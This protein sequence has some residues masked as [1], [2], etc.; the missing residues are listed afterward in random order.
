MTHSTHPLQDSAAFTKLFEQHHLAVFRFIYALSGGSLHE[1]EDLTAETFL[2]AWKSRQ[3][4]EGDLNSALGWL[5]TI[6]RHLV[7]DAARRNKVRKVDQSIADLDEWQVLYPQGHVV[8]VENQAIHRERVAVLLGE[9]RNLP[10]DRRELL[11]LRYI[12]GWQVKQIAAHLGMVENTASVYL[13]RA[14]EQIRR[15]WPTEDL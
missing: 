10:A 12:L 2:R 14:L 8:S 5:L 4:F 9:L 15:D 13:H 11:I 7:I 6:A 3:R 1:V